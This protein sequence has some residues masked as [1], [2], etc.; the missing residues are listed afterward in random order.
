MQIREGHLVI[1]GG[2]LHRKCPALVI[3]KR[4]LQYVTLVPQVNDIA[5]AEM[6]LPNNPV[7]RLI[8][9]HLDPKNE[10]RPNGTKR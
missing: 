8:S 9:V 3:H 2:S 4:L 6:K 1:I 5:A 7:M 10:T